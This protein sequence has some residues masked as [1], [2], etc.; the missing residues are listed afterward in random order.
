MEVS[1]TIQAIFALGATIFTN[2]FAAVL[3][4]FA[5]ML[6]TFTAWSIVDWVH[7]VNDQG[8]SWAA[9]SFIACLHTVAALLLRWPGCYYLEL[10][11][12]FVES[13]VAILVTISA[14][15]AAV[16]IGYVLATLVF[17]VLGF[18]PD[19][20]APPPHDDD[21]GMGFSPVR[22]SRSPPRSRRATLRRDRPYS[23]P[24]RGMLCDRPIVDRDAIPPS[25]Y[26]FTRRRVGSPQDNR[27]FRGRLRELE[28]DWKAP[29]SVD[30]NWSDFEMDSEG[31]AI[32]PGLLRR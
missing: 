30:G 1:P 6:I 13:N 5:V 12:N 11:F 27:S 16:V 20:L 31:A 8:G 28:E 32:A 10:N 21:D 22:R 4:F 17:A 25:T 3:C 14:F 19:T 2:A 23:P 26:T 15:E 18:Q 7:K 24:P 29:G 9:G